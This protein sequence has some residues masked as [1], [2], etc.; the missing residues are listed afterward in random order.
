MKKTIKKF[1]IDHFL[2]GK[3]DITNDESLFESGIIDSLKLLELIAFVEKTFTVSVNMGEVT[4][5][6]FDSVNNISSLIKHKQDR[7]LE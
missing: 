2:H 5:E 4:V 7:S 6:H 3:G 1:I